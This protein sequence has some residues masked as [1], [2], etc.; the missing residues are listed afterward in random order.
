M[1]NREIEV[2]TIAFKDSLI[3]IA[4]EWI[5]GLEFGDI[6][7][8]NATLQYM[9][10]DELAL[11]ARQGNV[12]SQAVADF[13]ALRISSLRFEDRIKLGEKMNYWR[14][15][16]KIVEVPGLEPHEI[17]HIKKKYDWH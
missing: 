15:W 10:D 5:R 6:R 16:A 12:V 13:L 9:N 14:T 7:L 2:A 17:N 4:Q 11:F 8:L 1:N 3:K